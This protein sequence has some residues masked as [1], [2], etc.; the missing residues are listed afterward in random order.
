MP[1]KSKSI[2][3]FDET[4]YEAEQ[5]VREAL[6]KSPKVQ[7]EVTKTMKAI[8]ALKAITRKNVLKTQKK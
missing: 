2:P 4:R 1:K 7:R 6:M 3:E 8:K 5:Q